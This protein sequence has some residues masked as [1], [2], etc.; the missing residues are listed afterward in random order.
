MS[1]FPLDSPQG[2]GAA[3]ACLVTDEQLELEV[4]DGVT[5]ERRSLLWLSAGAVGTL[6]SAAGALPAQDPQARPVEGLSFADFLKELYPLAKKVVDSKG[7]D[8]EAYLMTVAA[9][10]TRL[11]DPG[12]GLRQAMQDF[13]RQH[14]ESGKRFPINA[15]T[16][17]LR[18]GRGFKHHD[19]LNYNGVIMG[20][21]GEVRIKNYD[22]I[23]AVPDIKSPKSFQIRET[24]D[25]LILPGRISTL[26]CKRDNIHDLVAGKEGAQVLDVF[27]FFGSKV[28]S[29]YLDVESKPRDAEARIYEAA[30]RPRRRRR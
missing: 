14:G 9:A 3:D 15:M 19:H 28:G 5:V 10:M 18:P 27:T 25:D 11:R 17:R 2:L 13:R 6:L 22:F 30:W 24:R 26:G 23:G 21:E 1:F 29:R 12:N 8:E 7:K 16:M 4:A 20:I